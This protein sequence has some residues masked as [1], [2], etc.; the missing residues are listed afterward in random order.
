MAVKC[1]TAVYCLCIPKDLV[2]AGGAAKLVSAF[3]N[4]SNDKQAQLKIMEL[5]GTMVN[6]TSQ[7][8]APDFF[9]QHRRLST[10][11]KHNSSTSLSREMS[12]SHHMASG[13]HIKE[14]KE[15]LKTK[16]VPIF[17]LSE[18]I[19]ADWKLKRR[20]AQMAIGR[21]PWTFATGQDKF[22]VFWLWKIEQAKCI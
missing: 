6:D 14:K 1:V 10:M 5:L 17:N 19:S 21:K 3:K 11:E 7:L 22:H 16:Q 4:T 12:L 8:E 18:P 20:S 13:G 15:V 9:Q 2:K